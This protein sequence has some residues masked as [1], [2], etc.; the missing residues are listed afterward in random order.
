VS[1]ICTKYHDTAATIVIRAELTPLYMTGNI[2]IDLDIKQT[3]DC[4]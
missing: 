1:C 4:K 3:D 2:P